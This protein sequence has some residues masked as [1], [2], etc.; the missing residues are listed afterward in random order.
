MAKKR[1]LTPFSRLLITL[2]IVVALF[3]AIQWVLENTSILETL[4]D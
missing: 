2:V 1:R 3:F 4:G